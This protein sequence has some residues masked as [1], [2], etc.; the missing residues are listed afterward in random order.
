MTRNS[1]VTR[2]AGGVAVFVILGVYAISPATFHYTHEQFL[3][4]CQSGLA[5][6]E[7][8]HRHCSGRYQIIETMPLVDWQL[9]RDVEVAV[10]GEQ[11]LIITHH[12]EEWRKGRRYK[13]HYGQ[14]VRG[15]NP[16]YSFHLTGLYET[17]ELRLETF[18]M[19]EEVASQP[20]GGKVHGRLWLSPIYAPYSIGAFPLPALMRHP[21]FRVL[22]LSEG[23]REGVGVIRADFEARP[24]QPFTDPM[25]SW[26]REP[27]WGWFE[28]APDQEWTVRAFEYTYMAPG[29]KPEIPLVKARV[30]GEVSYTASPD[31]RPMVTYF[32]RSTSW[33][34]LPPDSMIE[35][36][37]LQIEY[38][39][40]SEERFRLSY[41]GL[42][43]PPGVTWEREKKTP[44]YVWLLVA[45]GVL[46]M[47]ALLFRWLA[48]R[49][50]RHRNSEA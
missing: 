50:Q 37:D 33:R 4:D 32:K 31:G 26:T 5:K 44:V 42:P 48:H 15:A 25:I 22:K 46:G 16:V 34:D 40:V 24:G 19:A 13:V 3:T 6:L 10:S 21:T 7:E 8:R 12:F 45:A 29:H 1:L 27:V 35:M 14:A 23:Q 28:V 49:R 38:G 11:W 47:L 17:R 30:N 39:P 18:E 43:E 9:I 41:Y 2:L 20:S 36:K